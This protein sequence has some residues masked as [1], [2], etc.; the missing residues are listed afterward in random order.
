MQ[1][2]LFATFCPAASRCLSLSRTVGPILWSRYN[3]RVSSLSSFH[4]LLFRGA[5]GSPV[6]CLSLPTFGAVQVRFQ[7]WG[8]Q[9]LTNNPWTGF[10]NKK[11]E[12]QVQG[13]CIVLLGSCSLL[14]HSTC[15]SNVINTSLS[16]KG[17]HR[18]CE[19]AGVWGQWKG[20]IK[21][22]L[23]KQYFTTSF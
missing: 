9:S 21:V 17:V 4:D 12:L 8:L 5:G 7:H 15:V 16:L 2:P 19:A 14:E 22:K 6:S 20:R 11:P 13:Y 1:M 3:R 23:T 18:I 10:K